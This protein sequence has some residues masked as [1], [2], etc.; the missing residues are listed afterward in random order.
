MRKQFEQAAQVMVPIIKQ[1]KDGQ[2]DLPTPCVE[3]SAREL[4]NHV[5]GVVVKFETAARGDR[6]APAAGVDYL[7]GQ[8]REKFEEAANKLIDVWS[9]PAVMDGEPILG[10]PRTVA[11]KLPVV[12]LTVH[13][14]DLA[15]ATGQQ[16]QCPDSL[17]TEVREIFAQLEPMRKSRAVFE[18][19]VE[20]DAAASDT[21]KMLATSGRDPNWT[22]R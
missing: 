2:L 16:Y 22:K 7:T 20:V 4:L 12:E 6:V 10:M 8:W 17:V 21:D 5:F 11:A 15:R 13:A 3:Y 14:W 19:P 1:V 18:E 9:D